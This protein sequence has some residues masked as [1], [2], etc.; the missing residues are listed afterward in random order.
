MGQ[1]RE[2]PERLAQKENRVEQ[3]V[4]RAQQLKRQ[5]QKPQ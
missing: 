4:N 5:Q 2:R 3:A 1:Q